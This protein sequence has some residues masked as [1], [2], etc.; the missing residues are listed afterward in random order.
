[1]VDMRGQPHPPLECLVPGRAAGHFQRRSRNSVSRRLYRL[2]SLIAAF[3][4]W[5]LARRFSPQ[6]L[7]ATLLFLVTP[8]FVVNGNSFESDMPFLAFWLLATALYVAAVDRRSRA[9]LA[10]SCVAMGLAALAANQAVFLVP[11]L[12]LYG[13]KWRAAAIATLTAPAVLLAWQIFERLTTGALP[14]SVLAG[15]LQSY[16]FEALGAESEKR[17]RAHRPSGV[18][19]VSRLVAAALDRD[20]RP[21]LLRLSTI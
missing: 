4:A 13:R 17:G 21:R 20:Y 7:L 9:L 16:G 11:I 12:F 8:A 14:A 15:Y 5:S 19:G 10:A 6:P 1:M 2:F 18:A 3:S